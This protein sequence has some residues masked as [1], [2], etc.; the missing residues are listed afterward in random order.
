MWLKF[1]PLMSI[2]H[3]RTLTP[4]SRTCWMASSWEPEIPP[5]PSSLT[6]LH[7]VAMEA[8]RCILM[9]PVRRPL[10]RRQAWSLTHTHTQRH[11]RGEQDKSEVCVQKLNDDPLAAP[12]SNGRIHFLHWSQ[13]PW[14]S[15]YS[16]DSFHFSTVAS[17]LFKD[18]FLFLQ[19]V[20]LACLH[21]SLLP[22]GV[23]HAL[24]LFVLMMFTPCQAA[25]AGVH[26]AKAFNPSAS[27][28]IT[29]ASGSSAAGPFGSRLRRLSAVLAAIFNPI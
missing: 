8:L 3:L 15:F 26:S 4:P 16:F 11:K 20:L 10:R 24:S 12:E 22:P 1:C 5:A 27:H 25:L 6:L 13:K 14:N 28:R 9:S 23:L 29:S 18:F 21:P 17:F 7:T 19:A 2:P